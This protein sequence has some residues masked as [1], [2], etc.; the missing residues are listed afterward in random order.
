[1]TEN[2]ERKDVKKLL[3]E[4]KPSYVVWDKGKPVAASDEKEARRLE[5]R[6]LIIDNVLKEM[7]YEKGW[8]NYNEYV[9]KMSQDFPKYMKFLDR[10][11]ELAKKAGV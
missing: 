5:G 7:G 4:R 2:T 3:Q 6:A 1:M 11:S 10:V 9:T 8:E